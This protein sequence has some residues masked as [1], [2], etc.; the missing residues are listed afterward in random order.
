MKLLKGGNYALNEDRKKKVCSRK[1]RR[2][3]RRKYKFI[4]YFSLILLAIGFFWLINFDT[5]V[6]YENPDY[7][8]LVHGEVVEEGGDAL[9][10]VIPRTKIHYK[11]SE[12]DLNVNKLTLSAKVFWGGVPKNCDVMVNVKS[13]EN[14]L[15]PM[16]MWGTWVNYFLLGVCLFCLLMIIRSI[17]G[18]WFKHGKLK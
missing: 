5:L 9:T 8:D 1:L 3:N 11:Y 16:D 14:I 4:P 12:K 6:F 13:P 2:R 7:Y 18:R 15:V 17:R 10:G